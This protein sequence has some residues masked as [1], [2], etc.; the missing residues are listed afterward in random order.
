MMKWMAMRA[1]KKPSIDR[2]G[3]SYMLQGEAGA[4]LQD[5]NAETRRKQHVR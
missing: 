1:D 2:I 4:D 5:V 3:I